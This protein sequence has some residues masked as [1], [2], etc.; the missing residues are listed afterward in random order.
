MSNR[1]TCCF[2]A[3]VFVSASLGLAGE[4]K[5]NEWVSL[6]D[7]E[8]LSGWSV[9]SGFAKYHVED[10]AIVGTTVKGSPN[11]F[12]CTDR[13]YGDFVLE[14]EVKLDPRLNSGVQIRSRIAEAEKAFVFSGRDGE[15]RRRVIPPDRVYGYQVE[16]ATEKSGSSGSI[17]DEARRAF[18]LA[19]TRSDPA[20]SKAFKD[21]RWNKFRIECKGER[22]RTWINDAAC[23]DLTDG[24][25]SRGIIGLQ[26]HG[27]GKDAGPYQV[28][29]RNIRIQAEDEGIQAPVISS[30][31]GVLRC[32]PGWSG[33]RAEDGRPLV[34]EDILKRMKNVSVTQ[35]WSIV[36]NAGYPNCYEN[37]AGWIV[38]YPAPFPSLASE[39]SVRAISWRSRV[40]RFREQEPAP[41]H[42]LS[43]RFRCPCP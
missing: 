13:Q 20:A 3:L 42:R 15:P 14:F 39:P 4:R 12:L 43:L 32:T 24:M 23:V 19:S 41:L 36:K 40:S 33:P 5:T 31:A 17:Y 34:P 6:F 21:G 35:A 2:I 10:G 18:M 1:R 27:V 29:W 7:G 26:V 22:I 28:R 37:A 25:T 11:T 9:H 30:R 8:T 38:M 16:I